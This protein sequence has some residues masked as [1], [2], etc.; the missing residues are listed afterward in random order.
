MSFQP[1]I[2]HQAYFEFLAG[3]DRN[4]PAWDPVLAGLGVL[5]LIDSRVSDESPGTTDWASLESTRSAVAALNEGDPIRSILFTLIDAVAGGNIQREVIGRGLLAYGRALNFEGRWALACDVLGA[6]DR[7]AGA[8]HNARISIESSIALGAAS[9]RMGDWDTSAHAYARA[10]HL[11]DT[12]GDNAATL[13]V[14]IG[15]ATTHMVRGNLPAAESML[16]SAIGQARASG[17]NDVLGRGLHLRATIAIQREAY[18]DAARVGYEALEVMTD[19]TARDGLISDIAAAFA[20]LGLRDAARD[21]Y[22]IVAATAQS[23]WVRWQATLN[24]MELAALD[25]READ[26]DAYAR[27]M[28]SAPL[29]PR[30]R[31]HYYV[32]LG[33][34]Q[35]RFGKDAEAEMSF[36]EGLAVAEKNQFH[37]IAHE[38]TIALASLKSH[39]APRRALVTPPA[40]VPLSLRKIAL[41]LSDL[42][43]AA[44]SSP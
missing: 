42:R 17:L 25:D 44:M 13:L 22:L 40:D 6:A 33:A 8:P 14:E 15:R 35:Q 21:G 41:E 23:Q 10:A 24:L 1:M 20:G 12:L 16:E 43:E 27:E 19:L 36:A 31:A 30:L 18:A 37:Q 2:S 32:F 4:A 9:R 38:A 11:A 34:G 3:S 5:R 26:F 7:I 28:G 29:D 39:E